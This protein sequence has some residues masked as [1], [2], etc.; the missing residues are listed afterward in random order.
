MNTAEDLQSQYN[1]EHLNKT[2]ADFVLQR[3]EKPDLFAW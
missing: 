1:Q 2:L 3:R